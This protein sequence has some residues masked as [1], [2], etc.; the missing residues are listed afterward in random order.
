MVVHDDVATNGRLRHLRHGRDDSI[1]ETLRLVPVR[2]PFAGGAVL[3]EDRVNTVQLFQ[4]L[5]HQ[6]VLDEE[7][8]VA[9]DLLA[10]DVVVAMLQDVLRRLHCATHVAAVDGADVHLREEGVGARGELLQTEI[11]VGVAGLLTV[12]SEED[13]GNA[14]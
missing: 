4:I 13:G 3:A 8:G 2:V 14:H 7:R 11:G 5:A 10:V 1:G 6:Q 12:T 9:D